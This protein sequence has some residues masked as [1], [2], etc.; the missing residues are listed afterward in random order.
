M[1]NPVLWDGFRKVGSFVTDE[2]GY[3]S[4]T[5]QHRYHYLSLIHI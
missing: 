2:N 5:I 1:D 3:G 4:Q